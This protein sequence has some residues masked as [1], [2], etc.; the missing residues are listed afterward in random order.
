M[1]KTHIYTNM[2]TSNIFLA[3]FEN[4]YEHIFLKA[5]QNI[6]PSIY[7]S[8]QKY[9]HVTFEEKLSSKINQERYFTEKI[10]NKKNQHYYIILNL[11]W[12]VFHPHFHLD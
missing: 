3:I 9:N 5:L 6:L 7:F 2:F 11:V 1:S 10:L 4:I 8:S 12:F